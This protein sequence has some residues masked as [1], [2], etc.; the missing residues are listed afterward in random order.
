ML[1]SADL[2]GAALAGQILDLICSPE[3]LSDMEHQALQLAQPRAAQIIVDECC[4][5]QAA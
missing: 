3:R 2:N 1:E 5:L 4:R